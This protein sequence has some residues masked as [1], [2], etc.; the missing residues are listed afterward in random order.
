MKALRKYLK[1]RLDHLEQRMDEFI[2][3]EESEKLHDVRVEIKKIKAFMLLAGRS[4]KGFNAHKEFIPYRDVFREAGAIREPEVNAALAAHYSCEPEELKNAYSNTNKE[5]FLLDAPVFINR[6][7]KSRKRLV[8]LTKRIT[9][10]DGKKIIKELNALVRMSLSPVV[11]QARLHKTRKTI[12]NMLYLDQVLNILSGEEKNFYT[13]VEVLIGE[14]HDKQNLLDALHE[15]SG[16]A[17]I[18]L[19]ALERKD[20]YKIRKL[21]KAFYANVA[22]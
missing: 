20:L 5:I 8:K 1:T 22:K 21:A 17:S 13:S 7:R 6:I 16:D 12:K 15:N 19:H 4:I 14:F 10:R 3:F 2:R 9:K 18:N 11:T